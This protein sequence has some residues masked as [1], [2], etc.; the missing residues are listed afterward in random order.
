M[1]KRM[2]ECMQKF[3]F[4]VS[5]IKR[6]GECSPEIKRRIALGRT[7]M[8]SMKWENQGCHLGNQMQISPCNY[9][10]MVVKAGPD[11]K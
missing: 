1:V 9:V 2:N 6:S 3:T 11:K 7:A 5:Q 4:L 10:T 8:M